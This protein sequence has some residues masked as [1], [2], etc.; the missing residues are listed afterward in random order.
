M[1]CHVCG[2][3]SAVSQSGATNASNDGP[4]EVACALETQKASGEEPPAACI[5]YR[6]PLLGFHTNVFK[7]VC[8]R[9]KAIPFRVLSKI[10][11][12]MES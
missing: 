5:F 12:P 8:M 9:L 1:V 10:S 3:F 11:N 4:P 6:E 2:W 7:L